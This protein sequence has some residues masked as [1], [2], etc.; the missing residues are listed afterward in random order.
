MPLKA[1]NVTTGRLFFI[2]Y[3]LS[4]FFLGQDTQV[5]SALEKYVIM[6]NLLRHLLELLMIF[7]Y[8]F[9]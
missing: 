2:E 3:R 5:A 6:S 7:A 1:F 4:V 8:Y 9:L